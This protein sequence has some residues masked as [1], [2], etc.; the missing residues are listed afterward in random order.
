MCTCT[1][2]KF[3]MLKYYFSVLRL[4]FLKKGEDVTVTS[5][6]SRYMLFCLI[7]ISSLFSLTWYMIWNVLEDYI[8][9]ALS[10][11]LDG[12]LCSRINFLSLELS[13]WSAYCLSWFGTPHDNNICNEML[14][15]VKFLQDFWFWDLWMF[16]L[17]FT[18]YNTKFNFSA[19]LWNLL[20]FIKK[21]ASYFGNIWK[22]IEKI[23]ENAVFRENHY[24]SP[25]SQGYD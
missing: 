7:G 16:G 3:D 18:W 11:D 12:L 17:H 5:A 9:N 24:F 4:P 20:Q 6:H 19:K 14:Q 8:C 15:K 22:I 21:F 13:G 1:H 25:P 2:V 23:V 10:F